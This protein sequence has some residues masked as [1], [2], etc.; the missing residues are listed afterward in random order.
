MRPHLPRNH[1][2]LHFNENFAKKVQL[3]KIVL[4]KR[5]NQNKRTNYWVAFISLHLV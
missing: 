1:G 4:S 5:K 2:E 3:F